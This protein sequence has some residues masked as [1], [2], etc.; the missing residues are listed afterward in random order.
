MQVLSDPGA[1]VTVFA[2]TNEAFARGADALGLSTE[3]LLRSRWLLPHVTAWEAAVSMLPS[4]DV[5]P[6]SA[7]ICAAL[8]LVH[9]CRNLMRDTLAIHIIPGR[10]LDAAELAAAGVLTPRSGDPLFVSTQAGEDVELA[11][12]G[13]SARWADPGSDCDV[14]QVQPWQV[15]DAS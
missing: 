2:P 13:S 7:A 6:L 3:G 5:C 12:V 11:A 15:L 1:N 8:L 14:L 10:R 9:H 4:S